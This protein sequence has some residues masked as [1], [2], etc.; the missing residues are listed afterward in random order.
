MLR[1]LSRR[2]HGTYSAPRTLPSRYLHLDERQHEFV[3]VVSGTN[4]LEV[5][6]ADSLTVSREFDLDDF[7]W[8]VLEVTDLAI[9]PQAA[10]S[11]VCIQHAVQVP[12]YLILPVDE[13][14]GELA[15]EP[16]LGTWAEIDDSGSTLYAGYHDSFR[17]GTTFHIKPDWSLLATPKYGQ[18]DM[19]LHY[20]LRGARAT[21][22]QVHYEAGS[23]G[24]G[25]RPDQSADT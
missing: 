2:G 12:R 16:L 22:R 10:V 21:M 23:G 19:L 5:I 7:G 11:Y 6:D 9:H 13:M 15:G 24:S 20:E 3:G 18:I 17:N 14:T 4:R 8:R 25:I 1:L